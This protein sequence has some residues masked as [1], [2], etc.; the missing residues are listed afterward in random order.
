MG[1]VSLHLSPYEDIKNSVAHAVKVT[2]YTNVEQCIDVQNS[3]C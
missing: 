3:D 1:E 2:Q